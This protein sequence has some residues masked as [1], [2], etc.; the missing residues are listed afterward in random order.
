MF[1]GSLIIIL[2]GFIATGVFLYSNFYKIILQTE[3]IVLIQTEAFL[4]PVK[5]NLLNKAMESVALKKEGGTVKPAEL[6]N[7]FK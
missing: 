5:I 4:E 1:T 2:V 7:P 6:R 3:E